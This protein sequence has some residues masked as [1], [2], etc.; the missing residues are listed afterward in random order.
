MGSYLSAPIRDKHSAE[1]E[2]AG[3]NFGVSEMQGWRVGM[4]DA[5]IADPIFPRKLSRTIALF[6]VFDG[7]G[8]AE[9][10]AYCKAH[11]AAV[12]AKAFSLPGAQEERSDK[13]L[14]ASLERAFLDMDVELRSTAGAAELK[15]LSKTL[16][17]PP[18][19][20]EDAAKFAVRT[21][22]SDSTALCGHTASAASHLHVMAF[23]LGWFRILPRC[24]GPRWG[25]IH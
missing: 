2:G 13:H 11:F 16:N 17:P 14:H 18:P 21:A 20:L 1:G 5:Y 12:F 19:G 6:A 24:V 8:G 25:G 4:E 9:V 10:S 7:H 22:P 15:Q 23:A 3:I